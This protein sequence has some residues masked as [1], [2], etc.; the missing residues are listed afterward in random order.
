MSEISLPVQNIEKLRAMIRNLQFTDADIVG[1]LHEMAWESADFEPAE[2]VWGH[3]TQR[4]KSPETVDIETRKYIEGCKDVFV[5]HPRPTLEKYIENV[6]ANRHDRDS[7]KYLNREHDQVRHIAA[8]V[9]TVSGG[10]GTDIAF[11][12]CG[13]PSTTCPRI[14]KMSFKDYPETKNR[15]H[16]RRIARA[17]IDNLDGYGHSESCFVKVWGPWILTVV[18][19]EPNVI[20]EGPE[21]IT[22]VGSGDGSEGICFFMWTPFQIYARESGGDE[23][24]MCPKLTEEST[25]EDVQNYMRFCICM[26]K[27]RYIDFSKDMYWFDHQS[28]TLVDRF[29]FAYDSWR[30]MIPF[31]T[32]PPPED[33]DCVAMSRFAID[34]P[35]AWFGERD[36]EKVYMRFSR[37]EWGVKIPYWI[38][39]VDALSFI[40]IDFG[41]RREVRSTCNKSLI[42]DEA[43][44]EVFRAEVIGLG[45]SLGANMHGYDLHSNKLLELF[46]ELEIPRSIVR[47]MIKNF[48]SKEVVF[49]FVDTVE[50]ALQGTLDRPNDLWIPMNIPGLTWKALFK[51][52]IR[53]SSVSRFGRSVSFVEGS[54]SKKCYEA[55]L[56]EQDDKS[57]SNLTRRSP[58]RVSPVAA[59]PATTV[60]AW[61]SSAMRFEETW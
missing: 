21:G 19:N 40:Y 26:V 55:E 16:G 36:V 44:P 8:I 5:Q 37:L 30:H 57:V 42:Y 32:V 12:E 49:A 10:Q 46:E 45:A 20:F 34:C 53:D 54:E 3:A 39:F 51:G 35:D 2:T 1:V 60:Q 48:Y 50:E 31:D 15:D 22:S 43:D 11:R 38:K 4:K 29:L 18:E 41:G 25:L 28:Y 14:C 23:S 33:E 61:P 9:A 24:N 17:V 6:F 58:R 56:K 52:F 59:Q 47:N 7:G 13:K 27:K